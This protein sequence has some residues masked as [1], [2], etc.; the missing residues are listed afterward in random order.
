VRGTQQRSH[1]DL[2][3]ALLDLALG[4]VYVADAWADGEEDDGEL[5]RHHQKGREGDEHQQSDSGA[6]QSGLESKHPVPPAWKLQQRRT[7]CNTKCA[8]RTAELVI[9]QLWAGFYHASRRLPTDSGILLDF[10]LC[11]FRAVPMSANHR[12]LIKT[13]AAV[14]LAVIV[15]HFHTISLC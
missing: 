13:V 5:D 1:L 11:A 9:Q 7:L 15:T 12:N 8:A 14:R 10:I 4:N 2:G 6:E 3:H